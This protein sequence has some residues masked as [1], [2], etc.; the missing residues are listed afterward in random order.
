MRKNGTRDGHKAGRTGT[1]HECHRMRRPPF[2]EN[3]NTQEHPRSF[4]GVTDC[5]LE[6]LEKGLGPAGLDVLREPYQGLP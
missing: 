1:G 4:A 3:R 5:P 6:E 2:L